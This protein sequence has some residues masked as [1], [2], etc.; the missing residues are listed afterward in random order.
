M[1]GFYEISIDELSSDIG[2]PL[3]DLI[4]SK[5]RPHVGLWLIVDSPPG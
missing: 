1:H 3:G 4:D 5:P 2:C